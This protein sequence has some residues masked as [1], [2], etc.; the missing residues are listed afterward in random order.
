MSLN[1][2]ALTTYAT[3]RDELGLT[4]TQEETALERM[5]NAA[6]EAIENICGRHFEYGSAVV[7]RVRGEGNYRIML[8]RTPV[9]SITSITEITQAGDISYT[10][11]TATYDLEDAG[12]GFVYREIG[13]PWTAQRA[14]DI[15]QLSVTETERAR[16]IATYAGGWVTPQ[17]AVND[18]TLTR[19]LP[20]D[21]EEA[22]IM[23]V[24]SMWRKRGIDRDISSANADS[25]PTVSYRT[26]GEII[27]AEALKLISRYRRVA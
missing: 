13:W 16:V 15:G 5:I 20:S 14:M 11:D 8:S 6:S 12:S 3:V 17:Q 2:H 27:P 9:L 22:C 4:G 10:Y 18:N 1:V 23:S 21:L 7:E 24:V 19:S 26:A 25:G